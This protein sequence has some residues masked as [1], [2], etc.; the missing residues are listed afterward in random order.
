M[1][2][3]LREQGLVENRGGRTAGLPK[4]WWLTASGEEF[5]QAAAGEGSV[6]AQ[7]RRARVR[8][9]RPVGAGR[10]GVVRGL[11]RSGARVVGRTGPDL[12]ERRRVLLL[13]AAVAMVDEHGYADVTVAH[14][15]GRAKVS[16]RTFY[17]VFVDREQCLLA[18]LQD[19]DAQIT[20]ELRAADL[21]G[22]PWRERMR[23]GCGWCCG[24]LI[25]SR[26][27]RGFVLLSPRAGTGRMAAYREQLLERITSVFAGGGEQPQ[28]FPARGSVSPLMAEGLAG[29]IVSILSTRLPSACRAAGAGGPA[30]GC[31]RGW[32]CSSD[33]LGS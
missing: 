13:R 23:W 11:Q 7:V 5:L 6:L 22:L 27:W 21:D 15:A 3:R 32:S 9:G 24:F 1:L 2:S 33:F 17:E 8:R 29:A 26:C 12:A 16:R 30:E 20:A 4:A 18:V 19:I 10:G 31:R 28:S 25:V 14:I